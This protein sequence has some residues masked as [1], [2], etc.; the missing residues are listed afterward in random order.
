VLLAA[1][2]VSP[3]STR[4]DRFTKRR[5][6]QEHDV[7]LYWIIDPDARVAEIWRPSDDLPV[8]ERQRLSWHPAGAATPFTLELAELF[9]PI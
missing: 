5:L 8:V 2:V 1:E 3:S 7:P 9:R 4:A 6:Y